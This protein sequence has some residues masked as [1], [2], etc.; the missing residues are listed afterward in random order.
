[1]VVTSSNESMSA[2]AMCILQALRR[3][4]WPEDNDHFFRESDHVQRVLEASATDPSTR[5]PR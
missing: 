4:E 1:M 2:E 3:H 5:S